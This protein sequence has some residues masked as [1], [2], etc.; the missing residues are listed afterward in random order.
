MKMLSN[1]IYV[2]EQVA[3]P[4]FEKLPKFFHCTMSS[5]VCKIILSILHLPVELLF[6]HS[7]AMAY[8]VGDMYFSVPRL[9]HWQY[10]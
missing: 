1:C 6:I 9:W 2:C 5:E 8:M 10:D 4:G 3:K 7:F